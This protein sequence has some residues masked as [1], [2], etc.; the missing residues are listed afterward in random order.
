MQLT[1]KMKEVANWKNQGRQRRQRMQASQRSYEDGIK[2]FSNESPEQEK[3]AD[4]FVEYVLEPP[5]IRSNYKVTD[6]QL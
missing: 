6:H 5:S 1:L 3:E 2:A 4:G